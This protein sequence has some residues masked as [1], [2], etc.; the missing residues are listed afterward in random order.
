M[1]SERNFAQSS[2]FSLS[3][4]INQLI[5]IVKEKVQNDHFNTPPYDDNGSNFSI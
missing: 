5:T 4:W 3:F 2:F 1:M